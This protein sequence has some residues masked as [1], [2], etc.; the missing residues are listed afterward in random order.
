MEFCQLQDCPIG[1]KCRNLDDGYEC[2]ANV[3]LRGQ[4]SDLLSYTLV[5]TS[6]PKAFEDVMLDSVNISYRSRTGGTIL[7]VSSDGKFYF[8]VSVFKDEITVA[9][10]LDDTPGDIQR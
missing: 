2:V 3:T 10:K 7:H 9:W 1:S 6:K 8:S 5:G 4:K